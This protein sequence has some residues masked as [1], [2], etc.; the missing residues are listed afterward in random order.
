MEAPDKIYLYREKPKDY[1]DDDWHESPASD[2]E[3]VEYIRKDLL[4]ELK[5]KIIAK[6]GEIRA[7]HPVGNF[8]ESFEGGYDAGYS[9]CCCEIED[10]LSDIEKSLRSE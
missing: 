7:E 6:I 10:I 2:V 9:S 3:N 8:G 5:E 4:L 1:F